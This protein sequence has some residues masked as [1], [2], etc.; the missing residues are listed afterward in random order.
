V[1][2]F[3]ELWIEASRSARQEATALKEQLDSME[4][5][6]REDIIVLEHGL[7]ASEQKAETQEAA[8]KDHAEKSAQ[9]CEA[10]QT[11]V[12]RLIPI[13]AITSATFRSSFCAFSI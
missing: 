1:D 7:E 3:E 13:S 4:Q 12:E 8:L 5:K 9:E 11:E 10:L 2:L 6:H